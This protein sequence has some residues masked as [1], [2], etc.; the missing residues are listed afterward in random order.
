MKICT[1]LRQRTGDR[2]ARSPLSAQAPVPETPAQAGKAL[3]PAESERTKGKAWIKQKER[4]GWRGKRISKPFPLHRRPM[5]LRSRKR[6]PSRQNL[7]R[8]PGS[9]IAQG[10]RASPTSACRRPHPRQEGSLSAAG[11]ATRDAQELKKT[12]PMAPSLGSIAKEKA[13]AVGVKIQ[14][15]DILAAGAET[16]GLLNQLGATAIV[17]ESRENSEVITLSEGG[18]GERIHRKAE[19]HRRGGRERNPPGFRRQ[20][21]HPPIEIVPGP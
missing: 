12:R 7:R 13:E 17:L 19:I 2:P 3:S 5:P 18:E 10:A 9:P 20:G 11:S 14:A 21:H 15:K 8:R 1:P 6:K 4:Q 16:I